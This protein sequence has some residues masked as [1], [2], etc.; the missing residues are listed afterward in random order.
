MMTVEELFLCKVK[1]GEVVLDVG[2][3]G[4]YT[5]SST[6]AARFSFIT[7][8]VPLTMLTC[9]NLTQYARCMAFLQVSGP[10]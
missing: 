6:P 5:F 3:L 9:S 1:D 7:V 2:F 10:L 8:V 4:L